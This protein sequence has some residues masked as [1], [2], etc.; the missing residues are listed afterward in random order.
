MNKHGYGSCNLPGNEFIP[1]QSILV[2]LGYSNATKALN[3]TTH[4]AKTTEID[5]GPCIKRHPSRYKHAFIGNLGRSTSNL[6]QKNVLRVLI[7]G[8]AK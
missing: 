1:W 4:I 6:L 3:S 5:L 2:H 8:T 7:S